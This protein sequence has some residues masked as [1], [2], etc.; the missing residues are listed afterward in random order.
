MRQS[1]FVTG[2]HASSWDVLELKPLQID[3]INGK[4]KSKHK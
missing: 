4:P 1:I 2:L 3:F